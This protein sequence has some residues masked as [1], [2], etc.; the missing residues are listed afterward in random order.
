MGAAV[1][2]REAAGVAALGPVA[3]GDG[4]VRHVPG[5][6]DVVDEIG[7]AT[8]VRIVRGGAD[9]RTPDAPCP[10]APVAV[11]AIPS[12]AQT[13]VAARPMAIVQKFNG[14]RRRPSGM[15]AEI[16]ASESEFPNAGVSVIEMLLP[17][18]WHIREAMPA[19]RPMT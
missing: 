13:I 12:S 4:T 19:A 1:S 18:Q 16:E 9:S 3:V 5:V 2:G 17:P 11:S 7:V 15:A 14:G 8:A 10:R 6:V